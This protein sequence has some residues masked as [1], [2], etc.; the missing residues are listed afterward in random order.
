MESDEGDVVGLDRAVEGI[1]R[2]HLGVH[3]ILVQLLRTQKTRTSTIKTNVPQ[4]QTQT[5]KYDTFFYI[6]VQSPTSQQKKEGAMM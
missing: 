4:G 1:V 5:R 6:D 3:A 2:Q